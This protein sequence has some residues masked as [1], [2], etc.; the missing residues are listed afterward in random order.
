MPA[1]K[2]AKKAAQIE[3]VAA[4]STDQLTEDFLKLQNAARLTIS[5]LTEA[6]LNKKSELEALLMAISEKEGELTELVGKEKVSLSL[7]ELE[8]AFKDSKYKMNKELERIKAEHQDAIDQMAREEQK[9]EDELKFSIG[10]ASRER[11]NAREDEDRERELAYQDRLR[12]ISRREAEIAE[13]Q[14]KAEAYK[15]DLE[16][17]ASKQINAIKREN[18]Y[19][20]KQLEIDHAA[21]NRI[22]EAD[23]SR[24]QEEIT[25]LRNRLEQAE[26]AAAHAAQRNNE[27]AQA[28]LEA[29]A[30]KQALDKIEGIAQEQARSGKR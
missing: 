6:F 8:E 24:L 28:A 21:N 14:H 9:A 26:L 22:A 30:G 2:P 23:I 16:V 18:D 19:R 13:L 11:Q 17:K 1:K 5:D 12:D 29:Q 25:V 20:V 3:A 27:I 15:Q 7:K 10:Q 4:K